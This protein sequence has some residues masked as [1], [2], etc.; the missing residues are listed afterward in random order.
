MPFVSGTLPLII[1]AA[2]PLI[3]F[4]MG[5]TAPIIVDRLA[6]GVM[7]KLPDPD[8]PLIGGDEVSN[9]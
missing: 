8:A 5:A 6:V 7:P 4:Y 2:T 1:D 9:A 3:A